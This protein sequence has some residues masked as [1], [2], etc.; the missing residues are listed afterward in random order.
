[1]IVIFTKLLRNPAFITPAADKTLL[2]LAKLSV[3]SHLKERT[4]KNCL[5]CNARV[6]GA[7]CHICGQEN[8]EPAESAWHLITHFFND[9][10]HFDGR[11]FSTLKL[12][13]TKPGFLS[14]E[15]KRGRRAS[16][17]NPVRMYVFTSFVFFIIFFSTVSANREGFFSTTVSGVRAQEISKMD[18]A[19]FATFTKTLNK[20]K[21]LTREQFKVYMDSM[22]KRED[23]TLMGPYYK[24]EKAYDSLIKTGKAKNNWLE[25]LMVKK[26]FEI[27][28]KYKTQEE[29]LR[30]F[31]DKLVHYFSQILFLSLPFF[32]MFLTF[33]YIRRKDYYFVANGIYSVHLYVFYFI[34]LLALLALDNL[35]GVT[36]WEFLDWLDT[37]LIVWLFVY[38]YK[39][40]R[41]FYGQRRAKTLFKFFL[42]IFGRLVIIVLLFSIFLLL[43]I[44]NL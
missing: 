4:D 13:I 7:F 18:S 8:I 1:L 27:K 15:Y 29:A 33:L 16:Y 26:N 10:T 32:A 42:A 41:H 19:E 31:V 35:E 40:M 11:F 36:G 12:L 28:K 38:E 20:G 25:R 24:N 21:V 14:A 17:L 23:Y 9:I 34:I 43:S 39:A 6:Q 2:I 44:Y 3:L 5:N 37:L 30:S 22:A